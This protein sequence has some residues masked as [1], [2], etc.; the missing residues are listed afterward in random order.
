MLLLPLL[1]G[2]TGLALRL[3]VLALLPAI[4]VFV[5]IVSD[6][7]SNKGIISEKHR[8]SS[9]FDHAKK[10]SV[11]HVALQ[12]ARTVRIF[13][14]VVRPPCAR[15]HVG[16]SIDLMLISTSPYCSTTKAVVN[17]AL[18]SNYV[19]SKG[20]SDSCCQKGRCRRCHQ[21]QSV[22]RRARKW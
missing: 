15:T 14:Y 8:Q 5:L 17:H 22:R 16:I 2:G 18:C 9:S 21:G 4:V 1:R 19:A 6:E 10:E 20:V 3:R 12:N 13:S 11:V 7:L